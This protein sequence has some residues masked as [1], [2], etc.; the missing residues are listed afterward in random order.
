MRSHGQLDGEPLKV[1]FVANARSLGA[2][3]IKAATLDE[4][5][6]ALKEAKAM[7]RTTVI[8]V[9]TDVSTSVPG[10]DSWWDVAV[11]EVSEMESVREARARYEEARK[12]ERYFAL[13][14]RCEMERLQNF[15]EGDWRTS[16]ASETLNVI[17]PASTAVLAEV[18]LSPAADVNAAVEVAERA[19]IALAADAG[20]GSR[21]AAVPAE[22][23]AGAASRR[24]GAL[25]HQRVRQD[26]GGE[27]GGDS[28]RGGECGDGVR[29]ADDDAG[30]ELRR[31][32]ARA[33]TST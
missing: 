25:H 21:A 23:A 10:Y 6:K 17:N 20:G 26:A 24:A 16:S 13:R 14:R 28:A 5:K 4:L 19:F 3:A 7:D 15:I 9:E 27:Q 12:R 29:H 1:D 31:H 18:P 22:D 8:V 32:C 30:N 33:S 11:A 2:H